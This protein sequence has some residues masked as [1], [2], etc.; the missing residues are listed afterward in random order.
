MLICQYTDNYI[1]LPCNYLDEI[2]FSLETCC[3]SEL[4]TVRHGM[5][6]RGLTSLVL[7]C[8]EGYVT[9]SYQQSQTYS[10]DVLKYSDLQCTGERVGVTHSPTPVVA[11]SLGFHPCFVGSQFT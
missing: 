8:D 5:I 2:C 7:S 4:P 3:P 1:S 11:P 6:E 9:P 10:C